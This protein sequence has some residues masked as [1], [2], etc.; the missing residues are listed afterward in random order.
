MKKTA[1]EIISFPEIECRKYFLDGK[2]HFTH[3]AM[4]DSPDE[5]TRDRLPR[6]LPRGKRV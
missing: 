3:E 2:V 1:A 5:S 6:G 4:I